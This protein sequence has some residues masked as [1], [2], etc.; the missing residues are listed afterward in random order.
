MKL[1]K[2]SLGR[3]VNVNPLLI[4]IFVDAIKTS[5]IDFGIPQHGGKRTEALNTQ[6]NLIASWDN[7]ILE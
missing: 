5:H 7:R 3:L 2:R 6:V 4:A 1:S